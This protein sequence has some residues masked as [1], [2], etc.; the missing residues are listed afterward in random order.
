VAKT[1]LPLDFDKEFV[2]VGAKTVMKQTA[3]GSRDLWMVPPDYLHI[4]P[5][6]NIRIV[7]APDYEQSIESLKESIKKGGFLPHKPLAALITKEGDQTF[8]NVYDGHRRLEAAKRAIAE[9]A[10]IEALPVVVAPPGTSLEDITAEMVATAQEAR[11]LS[12]MELAIA[13][14][15][16]TKFGWDDDRIAARFNVS[17]KYVGD[18][19]MLLG[20]PASVRTMV[21]SGKT[22]A[23]TAI[24]TLKEHGSN[25]GKALKEGLEKAEAA[26]KSRVTNKHIEKRVREPKPA[27]A[28]PASAADFL[29]SA[30]NYACDMP[31]T[32]LIWLD[33]W[34]KGDDLDVLAEL[35]DYMGQ[36]RGATN[37]A[38][39][40]VPMKAEEGEAAGEPEPTPLEQAIAES[41][42]AEPATAEEPDDI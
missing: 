29:L 21:I 19:L 23:S 28:R 26:G 17:K 41:R 40:R 25:A 37:D 27:V 15:R 10:Q 20:A 13:V 31:A 3:Q 38:S 22:A 34:R 12:P 33:A 14:G 8:I 7:D 1:P 5:G 36:P 16:F 35:E 9:G 32:G 18:L 30:I 4:M 39:L 2:Q 11:S 24:A 6:F 42:E